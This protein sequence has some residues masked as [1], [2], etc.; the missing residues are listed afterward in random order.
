MNDTD[1]RA[2][3]D[4]GTSTLQPDV[5]LL[6]AGGAA[7]GRKRLRRRRTTTAAVSVA[8]TVAAVAATSVGTGLLSDDAHLG[9]DRGPGFAEHSS[10]SP[11]TAAERLQRQPAHP[12]RPIT[13][14]AIDVPAAF[15]AVLPHA[16]G[17]PIHD[18]MYR[19]RQSAH[20]LVVSFHYDGTLTS[21]HIGP[22]AGNFPC[23]QLE[24]R[25]DPVTTCS[26]VDGLAVATM[27]GARDGVRNTEVS[28]WNHGYIV[29]AISYDARETGYGDGSF[30]EPVTD[31]PPIDV[32]TLLEL[33]SS[34]AWFAQ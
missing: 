7:R 15:A 13:V 5:D 4:G 16:V 33:T 6:V 18:E 27:H 9:R 19:T 20:E 31:A 32:D 8:A 21:F 3:L 1:L 12:D 30:E 24:G 29:S 34:E 11:T 14:A 22:A 17:A 2:M 26:V 23:D 28:V 25:D 10:T